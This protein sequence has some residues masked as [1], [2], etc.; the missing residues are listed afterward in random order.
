MKKL[1]I[2]FLSSEVTPFAKTGG[3]ADVSGALPKALKELGHEVRIIM[4]K[5]KIVNERKFVLR[6]V[7][8]LKD[9]PVKIGDDVKK[10][11]VKSAFTTDNI[12]IQTYFIDFRPYF[13]RAG[14]YQDPETNEE[15]EDNDERFILFAR[16]TLETLK[17]LFWQPD[18]IHCNDWQTA[19]VPLYLKTV[20]KDDE[21]FKKVSTV[22]S[23]HNLAFQGN[24]PAETYKKTNIDGKLFSIGSD[25]E[26][27]KKFSFLKTGIN[28]AD[29]VTTVSENYAKQI[30]ESSDYGFG[31]EG[32]LKKISKKFQGIINGVDYSI[33]DP[34][35]D[36]M[37][38]ENYTYGM[39]NKKVENK[40]ALAETF[41]L[42]FD[43]DIPV[44]GMISRMTE[45]KGF[46]LLESAA[47][48]LF[49]KNIQLVLLGYG[50]KE[51]HAK[52]EK[53]SKKYSDKFAVKF[54]YDD[55]LSHLV[56]AGSDMFLMPSKFEPCGLNQLFSLKY[57]TVPIVRNTGGL[58]DTI[59]EF[60]PVE[61]TGNGFVFDE[62]EPDA[63]LNAIERAID[64][65][66]NPK[67]WKKILKVGMK[68]DFSW[69]AS[70]KSYYK[71]YEKVLKK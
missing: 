41:G 50:D 42:N 59:Q 58:A 12:K 34:E 70:A 14:I 10:V 47:A 20:Y 7:I 35:I 60:D 55:E 18:I 38:P 15:Y 6:E 33:W 2:L 26:Y 49:E 63:M 23:I 43:P 11:N 44:I 65:Y 56:E 40:K 48:K 31:F 37:I 13:H 32:I 8:R 1:K 25:L 16:S 21:F 24:F 17:L 46:D 71:I 30:Q 27:Y 53:L 22:L 54:V 67:I 64:L 45:Q 29:Y 3:L 62:Y 57:G 19:L 68:Q 39:I 52:F 51:Y 66:K 61:S 9:I 5:Y 28:Y 36:E 4:P 69:K